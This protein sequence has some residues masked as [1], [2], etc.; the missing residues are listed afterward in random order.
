MATE[1]IKKIV[2]W[3]AFAFLLYAIFTNPEKSAGVV[4]SIWELLASGVSN[5]GRFFRSIVNG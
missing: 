5:M 4:H 3:V 1:K 2:I